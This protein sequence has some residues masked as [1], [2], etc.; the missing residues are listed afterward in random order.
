MIYCF[1]IDNTICRTNGSDYIN[2]QP[3]QERIDFI[4]RLYDFGHTV[5]L[6]TARGSNSGKDHSEFTIQQ[7][8]DWGCEY[9]ELRFGKPHYDIHI[10]DKSVHSEEFFRINI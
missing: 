5:I 4:N 8:K 6:M 9:N 2:S 1:D 7:L 10:D 3:I